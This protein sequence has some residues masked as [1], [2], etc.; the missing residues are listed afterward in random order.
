MRNHHEISLR[1]LEHQHICIFMKM[2]TVR[3]IFCAARILRSFRYPGFWPTAIPRY[4][5]VKVFIFQKQHSFIM[6]Y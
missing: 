3:E 1:L 4:T 5:A 2:L 6:L